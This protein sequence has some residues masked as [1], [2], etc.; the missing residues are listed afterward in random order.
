MP[1]KKKSS[2]SDLE[3]K[4]DELVGAIKEGKDCH[5]KPKGS[6]CTNALYGMG[7]LGA[8]IFYAQ[9][10]PTGEWLWTIVKIIFWPAVASYRLLGQFGL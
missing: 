6:S 7:I 10:P 5:C 4:F 1:V 3:S 2:K 8:V 9:H